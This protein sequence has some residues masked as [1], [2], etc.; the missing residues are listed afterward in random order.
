MHRHSAI[1]T[2]L[3]LTALL[4]V[5]PA[6]SQTYPVK[7]VRIVVPAAPGGGTDV[8]A[9]A[10]A[11]QLTRTWGRQVVVDNRPSPAANIAT[12]VVAKAP[13]DGY[14]L[15]LTTQALAINPLFKTKLPY[16]AAKD[17]V[18]VGATMRAPLVLLVQPALAVKSVR[19]LVAM[20]AAQPDKLNYGHSGSGSVDHV[21]G[22]L[23]RQT[24]GIRVRGVPY[25]G[26][27]Q[28]G[29]PMLFPEL[30]YAFLEVTHA[31]SHVK[32]G[33]ARALAVTSV[34]RYE[35]L[36][37]L[38]TVQETVPGFEFDGWQALFAPARTAPPVLRRIEAAVAEAM[39]NKPLAETLSA[40][41]LQPASMPPQEFQTFLRLESARWAKLVREANVRIE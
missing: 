23:F 33:Q 3:Y 13:P 38:P 10:L 28:P 36:P 18:P 7:S 22:E 29:T 37:N 4:H 35:L 8:A 21:C 19:E 11:S 30:Q 40:H 14:T 17:F 12:E 2:A 41:G 31:M 26:A 20:A 25:K 9:R 39:Q 32:A 34:K 15:L 1:R 27:L 5:S 24:A 6:V 16:D